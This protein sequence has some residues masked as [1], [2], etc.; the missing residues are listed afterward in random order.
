MKNKGWKF[1]NKEREFVVFKNQKHRWTWWCMPVIPPLRRLKQP[2]KFEAS[3]DY[4]ARPH[5]HKKKKVA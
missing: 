4:L 5:F 1:V 3:L 2:P